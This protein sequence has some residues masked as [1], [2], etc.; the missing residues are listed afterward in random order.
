MLLVRYENGEPVPDHHIADEMLTLLASGHETTSGS[1]GWAVERL[2][3]HPRCG[4][5]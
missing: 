3:R 2:T 1:L 5:G 4:R